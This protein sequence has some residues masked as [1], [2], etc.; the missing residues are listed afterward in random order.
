MRFLAVEGDRLLKNTLCCNLSAAAYTV[1]AAMTKASAAAFCKAQDC[2]LVVLDVN[3]SNGNG[4]D[5]CAEIEE[6]RSDTAVIKTS[7]LKTG[8]G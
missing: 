3:L 4:F 1:A 7:C 6:R 2:D 8:K 5:F